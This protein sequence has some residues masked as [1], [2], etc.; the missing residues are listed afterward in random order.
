[1]N[2]QSL[3]DLLEKQGQHH[4]LAHYRGL[5]P[6]KQ[7]IFIRGL[8]QLDFS[9]VFKL[10]RQFSHPKSSGS[11]SSRIEP[12]SIIPIPRT[13]EEIEQRKE[14]R[15]LGE[16]LI[17]GNQVA[18]LIVAGGQGT[19]L[20]FPGPKGRLPISPIKKKPLFQLFAESI[21]AISNRYRAN[22]PLLIMTSQENHEET[23]AFFESHGF[24][25]LERDQV[26][27]FSQGMLP[28]LTLDGKL[29]LKD[30]ENLLA[31]PDGH[32]G[33]LKALYESGLAGRLKGQGITEIF[34][35][36]VDN[37]LVRI[38]DPAF[39]G[40]HRR[41]K[42]DISTKVVRRQGLEEKVGI[43][44]MVNGKPAIIE[45]SDFSPED[46]RSLDEGGN[47]RY[48]AGNIAIHMISLSFVDRMNRE[49]FALP[50]HR[51]IKEVEGLGPG[52][53]SERMTGMK[54]EAF[55]FDSIPLA[56]KSICME[57]PREEEFAPVKNQSG[58][59]TPETARL[60]MEGLFKRWLVE[61]GAV[62][63]PQA[64]IEISP[65]FA[66]DKE[67]VMEKLKGKKL[68]VREDAYFE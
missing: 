15:K 48:W 46:Y 66:L 21:R 19:R 31:N 40:Y 65:L 23:R 63:A 25:S 9:S 2:P 64:R 32:G 60:A 61:A 43:Y 33:S 53:R 56:Q 39:I 24:F 13:A 49:G 22:L 47:I 28:T 3:L 45:Y 67:G 52:G 10:Y 30:A 12:A 17:R 1:M 58:I 36:Q 27:F 29:I 50:Y 18:V 34:Y 5:N 11:H 20:G 59:D 41:E 54:F 7:E 57:V 35:C 42:A 38:A 51:A 55:V 62:V 44:G 14:A 37:P 4:I 8:G 16:S 68:E 6:E 26:H